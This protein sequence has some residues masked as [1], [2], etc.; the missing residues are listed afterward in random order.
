[1]SSRADRLLR[2][3]LL[4]RALDRDESEAGARYSEER[5]T[6][7]ALAR[8]VLP[9][10]VAR[11]VEMPLLTGLDVGDRIVYER[12]APYR[13]IVEYVEAAAQR[14]SWD[15]P[16]G[17]YVASNAHA[18]DEAVLGYLREVSNFCARWRLHSTWAVRMIVFTHVHRLDGA[19]A[20][21][22]EIDMLTAGAERSPDIERDASW[23]SRHLLGPSQWSF[24]AIADV[25]GDG[26]GAAAVREACERY[27]GDAGLAL[28]G[29]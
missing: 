2:G 6:L 21:E 3:Q 9:T 16:R 27:A 28:P 24:E 17:M 29:A 25:I 22:R 8:D 20:A 7:D 23:L 1:V 12:P 11:A 4:L 19:E 13:H 26:A 5:A 18:P 10:V 14:F 15:D